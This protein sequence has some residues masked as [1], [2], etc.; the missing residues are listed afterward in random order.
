MRLVMK[1][2]KYK[3]YNNK[4]NKYLVQQIEIASEIWNFCIAM[5]R[6]Y[7]L[8]YGKNLSG[9]TLKKYIAKIC[10]R[11]KW[12]HWHN[13]G[14]QAIQDVVQR[15]VCLLVRSS[16]VCILLLNLRESSACL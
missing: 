10:K 1:A 16:C 8:V 11:R 3:L 4:K 13:L 6:M 12:A 2:Y 14:S 9:N 5:R 7:Y 15:R